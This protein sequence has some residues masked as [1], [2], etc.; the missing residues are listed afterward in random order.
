MIVDL[1]RAVRRL[2]PNGEW[3]DPA[4]LSTYRYAPAY[5]LL[6]DPGAGKSTAFEREQRATPRAEPVTA[7]DFRTIYGDG[8]SPQ[9]E[10]LFIDGLDEARAGG[11]DPRG[12]FDEIRTRLRQLTPK[13]VRISCRELDWLGE[14]DRTNLSTVA[15][16]GEVIVL[17]LEPLN[18]DEQRRIIGTDPRIADPAAFILEAADRGVESLLA[19]AQTLS[20]LVR[21]VAEDGAFPAGRTETFEKACLL[22]AREPNDEHRIAAPLPEPAT[23]VE[24]A[25]YMCA[26]S[27][28]SGAAGFS[29]PNARE[30]HGFVPTSRFGASASSAERA[31]HTRLFAGIWGGR[32]FPV[33]ANIAA[34][35]AAQHLARLVDGPVPGGRI[36]ALLTGTDGLP[37]TPLRS[38]VAWLAVASCTLRKTLIERDPVAVL[39]YGD[40][41]E[42][43]PNEKTLILDQ[44]GRNPDRLHEGWW[45]AS[46][47]AGLATEDMAPSLRRVLGDPERTASKQKVVE[48]TVTALR[49]AEVRTGLSDELL[50][51][52]RDETRW[53]PVRLAALDAWIESLRHERDRAPRLR[54]LLD[55]ILRGHTADP[56]KELL[57]TLLEAVYPGDLEPSEVW[58]YLAPQS[59][60]VI[61]RFHRFWNRLPET[62]SPAHL[63]SHLDHLAGDIPSLRSQLHD[64][65]LDD[66]PARLLARGLEVHGEQLDAPRLYKWLQV[67]L[68][69][70]GQAQLER[71]DPASMRRVR[72]WLEERPALQKAVIRAALRTDE[73]RK[74]DLVEPELNQRLYGSTLPDD[75]GTWHFNEAVAAG[76][77][78]LER[79]HLDEFVRALGS[80]PVAVDA[81]LEAARRRL[82]DRPG[83]LRYLESLLYCRIPSGHLERI[84]RWEGLPKSSGQPDQALLAAAQPEREKLLANRAPPGLLHS[85]AQKYYEERMVLGPSMGGQ[86]LLEALGGDESLTNAA[87]TAIRCTIEREDLPSAEDLVQL[88]KRGRMS[89]F[90]W[91]VL[92]GLEDRPLDEIMALG[93]ARLRVALACR[94]LQLGL[95]QEAAWYRRCIAE[96]PDLV[97]EVLILVGRTL[98]AARE[99]SFPDLYQ[100]DHDEWLAPVARRALL[101][102]LSAFPARARSA[103]LPLLDALLR[104]A[105]HHF[106]T[107]QEVASLRATIERKAGQPS[108]TRLVR[109]RWLAAGLILDP[110][111][112]LPRLDRELSG[113]SL[114]RR[115]FG[116][117][118][119]RFAPRPPEWLTNR[120]TSASLEFLVRTLGKDHNPIGPEPRFGVEIAL[121]LPSL[122]THLSRLTDR[123]ASESL[124]RLVE[125]EGLSRWRPMLDYSRD[126]QRVL[127]RDSQHKPPLPTEVIA[128]LHDGPP[129]S[130]A[131]LRELVLDRL[132]QI[133]DEVRT[134]NAN[135][136][137]Q[138]WNENA[139]SP[140]HEN[141]C[142]DAL[143]AMLRPRLPA[144]C[145][146]QPEGQYAAN[147]RADIRVSSGQWNVPVEIKKNSRPEVWS[148]VRNQLLPRY[149]NDPTSQGL[150]IYLVLWSGPQHTAPTPEGPRPRTPEE[151]QDRLLTNLTPEERRRAAVLVTDVTP[152]PPAT[153]SPG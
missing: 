120:L 93:G 50:G 81:T 29:L 48:V 79:K 6:G 49:H 98:L 63:A 100:L 88:R 121:L 85:L 40:V 24:I 94:L 8:L 78:H 3:S 151:L 145:D 149:T 137:R 91:P 86:H 45:S 128:T 5:V 116:Q 150:G 2:E 80:R 113:S 1:D 61:K 31:A 104:G 139:N 67:G 107:E 117:F 43:T 58:H 60:L 147:R 153:Q 18:A 115:S 109:V 114:R 21:V 141:T 54:A 59:H 110:D 133:A 112:F 25:S 4:P 83:V 53:F 96:R 82:T 38:L 103:Q 89:L 12:P 135:L 119:E 130:A 34:F 46:A 28:L 19:N 136:W 95:A 134:T 33:H 106:R 30:T 140:K 75:I 68:N 90:V 111:Q 70:W 35:L 108:T 39:M 66:L 143:L 77:A 97:A 32:F 126:Q 76:D 23:L 101:P 15:P 65:F 132:L 27:L 73:F 84:R 74:L 131:D 142:R 36:L 87:Q 44:I 122:I 26:V 105:L 20:L 22:L 41:R 99:K 71:G 17:R 118:F 125:Q 37:P 11:D 129:A 62:C 55:E 92:I 64:W 14:N 124:D 13:R 9:T 144:G 47:V 127:R 69:E 56:E 146:A 138:F 42:F 72:D 57:G 123:H 148:A 51:A 102:L 152:P 16:G 52:C 7:R 10:T